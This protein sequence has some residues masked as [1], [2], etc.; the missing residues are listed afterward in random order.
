MGPGP[1]K[2]TSYFHESTGPAGGGGVFKRTNSGQV[3][4]RGHALKLFLSEFAF[5][6]VPYQIHI[7][8]TVSDTAHKFNISILTKGDVV[9]V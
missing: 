5:I 4:R 7:I 8:R 2:F 3:N 9:T 6:D 1:K